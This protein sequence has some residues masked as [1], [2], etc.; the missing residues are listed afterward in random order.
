MPHLAF[1]V[2]DRAGA[3]VGLSGALEVSA[4]RESPS[5]LAQALEP[6]PRTLSADDLPLLAMM[7]S[8]F[9]EPEGSAAGWDALLAHLDAGHVVQVYPPS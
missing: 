3:L 6:L 2:V 4:V 1:H 5:T 7:S 9:V 8:R